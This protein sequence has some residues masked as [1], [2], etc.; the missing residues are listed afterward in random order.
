[1]ILVTGAS[2][3]NGSEL[4][5][6]LSEKGARVRAMSRKGPAVESNAVELVTADFDDSASIHC[7][8]EGVEQ[9]FL[10]TPSSEKVEAQQ[11]SF[12]EAARSA[13]VRNLV[14]LSQLHSAKDSPVRFL[15]YHAVVEE[16]IISSG[17]T[18]TNLRPNLW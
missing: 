6:L 5:K 3:S 15:R 17:M 7:A 18:F 14:Y 4:L 16:A 8:L 13:G 12:V 11:L 9:A 1:M 10:V 2:G